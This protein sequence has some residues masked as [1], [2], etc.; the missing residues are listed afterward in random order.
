[1]PPARRGG[2]ILSLSPALVSLALL[3]LI[4]MP[5]IAQ[6]PGHTHSWAAAKPND[7]PADWQPDLQA[8]VGMIR[9]NWDATTSSNVPYVRCG[10]TVTCQDIGLVADKDYCTCTDGVCSLNHE[11]SE[12]QGTVVDWTDGDAG[13][14]FGKYDAQSQWVPMGENCTAAQVTHYKA[15][16]MPGV[17]TVKC[18][19]NDNPNAPLPPGGPPGPWA[20]DDPACSSKEVDVTVYE[21]DISDTD[22][23]W[24]PLG[25]TEDNSTTYTARI[26]PTTDHN[27]ASMAKVITFTLAS[28]NCI[29]DAWRSGL[30]A[31][32]SGAADDDDS[33]T[34]DG[35]DGDSLSAYEEYRG[36]LACGQH[37][38]LD[39]SAKEVA[40]QPNAGVGNFPDGTA[41]TTRIIPTRRRTRSAN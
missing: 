39:P 23:E 17:I 25:G 9:F 7:P 31:T 18:Q 33:P 24:L 1:M 16:D 8:S 6:P 13:G 19:V 5:A 37:T 30:G 41:L 3:T 15:P 11:A 29:Q 2:G 4:V 35:T 32:V 27:S 28:T 40:I 36:I 10:D 34:G 21:F 20:D 38:R 14:E 12:Y 26:R 22:D